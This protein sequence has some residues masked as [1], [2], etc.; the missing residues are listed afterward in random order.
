MFKKI[1]FM[2]TPEFSVPTLEFLIKNKNEI[3]AVYSQPPK[4]AHRGQKINSS[5]VENFAR[6]N[7]IIVKTPKTLDT[8][9]EYDFIKNLNPDIVVVVAYGKIIPKRFLNLPKHGFINVH[10][11]LLPKWRGAAPIQRSIM[12]LDKETG[13]SIMKITE[14]LDAGPI[15]H[16]SKIRINQN[17]NSKI[18]SEILSKLGAKSLIEAIEKIKNK[19]IQLKEQDH[20]NATY[21]K[22]INK[23]EGKI[24]WSESAI[25]IL[26]KID[27][28]NPNPGAWFEYKQERYK[29]WK[30]KIV[31]TNGKVGFTI[32]NK[33][34]IACKDNSIQILEIQKEGK[35]K[36][37]LE[38]FLLGNPI[39][40]GENIV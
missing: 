2:G 4:K 24:E 1:I 31:E 32:D 34:T 23:E 7:S 5:P 3:L 11:S 8:N 19:K 18:L 28:L 10:A 35:N 36:L 9:E 30:A 40:S 12:N 39:Q 27:G 17:M 6:K 26:A 20:S 37:S 38:K 13:V 15:I 29:V 33:L 21:A 16:Q 14:E 22:K 25:K